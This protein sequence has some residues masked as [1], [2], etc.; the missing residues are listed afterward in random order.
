MPPS[1]T[2]MPT[3]WEAMYKCSVQKV[4][5]CVWD[6]GRL[7]PVHLSVCSSSAH[8]LPV[9][10]AVPVFGAAFGW[11]GEGD[12]GM[13]PGPGR[14]CLID[15]LPHAM[16][17]FPERIRGERERRRRRGDGVR[18]GGGISLP[19]R[20][21]PPENEG[22]VGWYEVVVVGVVGGGPSQA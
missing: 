5:V 1:H 6:V 3:A 18:E 10:S 11:R 2:G 22:R 4:G 7:K 15:Y 9:L 14:H 21:P 13:P 20:L 19:H 12:G 8:C 16:L 17:I